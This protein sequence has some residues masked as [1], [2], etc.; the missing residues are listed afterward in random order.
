MSD[1]TVDLQPLVKDA[2]RLYLFAEAYLLSQHTQRDD[3]NP[4]ALSG[5]LAD[6]V[7]HLL[8]NQLRYEYPSLVSDELL[9]RWADAHE[10]F[11]SLL[12]L[13]EMPGLENLLV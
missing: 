11:S 9:N 13:A 1:A 5:T 8:R 6:W 4:C 10:R 12:E 2:A 3:I 7:C